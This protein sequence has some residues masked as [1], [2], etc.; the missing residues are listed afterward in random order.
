MG[1]AVEEDVLF[2]CQ[3]VAVER[4]NDAASANTAGTIGANR[5]ETQKKI[6]KKKRRTKKKNSANGLADDGLVGNVVPDTPLR[7]IRS[8]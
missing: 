4:P 5:N 2:F 3:N 8:R 7:V 6:E 1:V